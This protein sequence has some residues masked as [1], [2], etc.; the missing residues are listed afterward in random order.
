MIR[1][2]A[3]ERVRFRIA[4]FALSLI[5][6]LMGTLTLAGCR[7]SDIRQTRD[8]DGEPVQQPLRIWV[9]NF[10]DEQA[11]VHLN[12]AERD[13][14]EVARAVGRAL[15]EE[16]VADMENWR[17]P[18]ERRTGPLDV[19]E[20]YLAIHG[21]VL[22]V[23]EGSGAKRVWIGFGSGESRVESRA[24]LYLRGPQGPQEIAE[25]EIAT[26]SGA[27]PGILT[28][29]PIGMLWHA[30]SAGVEALQRPLPVETLDES[31]ARDA[32]ASAAD[33][34]EALKQFFNTNG[35]LDEDPDQTIDW[36]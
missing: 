34:S 13:E 30:L 31:V 8:Y 19:P 9:Y 22:R 4:P 27:E 21:E 10:R 5:L 25:Y 11:S 1:L 2:R 14:A 26:R 20:G 33:W 7:S 16:L 32:R 17:I 15:A 28:T 18:I 6:A 24:R 12:D 36:D 3:A 23:E 29:L 35:W